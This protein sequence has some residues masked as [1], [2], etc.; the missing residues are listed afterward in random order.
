MVK[1]KV[2]FI[3]S[4][5]KVKCI[6]FSRKAKLNKNCQLLHFPSMRNSLLSLTLFCPIT[7]R[8]CG[9]HGPRLKGTLYFYI[10][11]YGCT[12]EIFGKE[13]PSCQ[14]RVSKACS[15]CLGRSTLTTRPR[16]K[17]QCNFSMQRSKV[18]RFIYIILFKS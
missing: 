1:F 4:Y 3:Y 6:I 5:I 12:I 14:E 9:V 11:I 8:S 13:V 7:L 15:A 10:T 18:T 17:N 2:Q 16:Q